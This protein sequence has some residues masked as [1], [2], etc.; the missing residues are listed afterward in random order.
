MSVF[1]IQLF[2]KNRTF[3]GIRKFGLIRSIV[4]FH[5]KGKVPKAEGLSKII[6][7]QSEATL[8]SLFYPGFII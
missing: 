5:F 1:P 2:L 3:I 6:N 7:K 4:P 8:A